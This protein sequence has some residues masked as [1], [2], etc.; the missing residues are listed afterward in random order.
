M[1]T[2][3]TEFIRIEE[4]LYGINYE[5]WFNLYGPVDQGLSLQDALRTHIADNC[6]IYGVTSSSKLE[7]KTEIM[8][9]VLYQGDKGSGPLELESKKTEIIK[10]LNE[11]FCKI[12]LEQAHTI[13]EFAF[14]EGSPSYPVFWDFAYDIHSEGQRWILVGSSSD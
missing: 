9:K 3:L 6:K 2:R 5:V 7:A 1:T 13:S 12:K 14:K 8:D 4:L 10:L 11:V